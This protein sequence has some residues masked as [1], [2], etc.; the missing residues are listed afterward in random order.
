[1]ASVL[2]VVG[3]K[4]SPAYPVGGPGRD[5]SSPPPECG[6]TP[7]LALHMQEVL[8]WGSRTS[9]ERSRS[10]RHPGSYDA[11]G[12]RILSGQELAHVDQLPI[13]LQRLNKVNLGIQDIAPLPYDENETRDRGREESATAARN[14][15]QIAIVQDALMKTAGDVECRPAPVVEVRETG[16]EAG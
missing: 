6:V 5:Q 11:Q 7:L 8:R 13:A 16:S 15:L 14:D 1:M 10:T 3:F 4:G 9:A 12:G 2:A